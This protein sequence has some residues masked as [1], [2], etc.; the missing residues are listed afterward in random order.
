MRRSA[1]MVLAAALGSMA[2]VT[3]R[4]AEAAQVKVLPQV[5]AETML[6]EVRHER[7]WQEQRRARDRARIA[8]AARREARR[9]EREREE[10][11]AWHH[12]HRRYHDHHRGG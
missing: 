1:M 6:Q 9:I 5:S 11:R 2:A 8:E 3:S 7:H 10:R 12:A 4:P